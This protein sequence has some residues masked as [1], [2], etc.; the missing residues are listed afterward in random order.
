MAAL[1]IDDDSA[2]LIRKYSMAAF[3]AGL[4][5]GGRGI[6]KDLP[7]SEDGKHESC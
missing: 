7:G 4:I 6:A 2:I 1:Q 3:T 5:S